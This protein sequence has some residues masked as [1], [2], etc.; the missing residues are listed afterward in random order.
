MLGFISLFLFLFQT[1]G[2]LDSM[3]HK[4][5]LVFNKQIFEILHIALFLSILI[6]IIFLIATVKPAPSHSG[7]RVSLPPASPMRASRASARNCPRSRLR[8][9]A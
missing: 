3:F 4:L 1:F 8:Q 7:R 2:L 9:T 6:Y 5:N